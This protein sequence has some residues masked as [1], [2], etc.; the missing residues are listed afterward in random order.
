MFSLTVMQEL[1]PFP[2]AEVRCKFKI[3]NRLIFYY[4]VLSRAVSMFKTPINK[5]HIYF[6]G[7]SKFR[8]LFM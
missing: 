8:I 4:L 6:N 3:N 2:H 7:F 1:Y 5:H